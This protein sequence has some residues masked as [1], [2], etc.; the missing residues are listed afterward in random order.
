MALRPG[1]VQWL[2]DEPKLIY[3]ARNYNTLPSDDYF[4]HLRFMPAVAG[5]NGTR[6][7][8][9][10][11]APVWFYQILWLATH[12]L[13]AIAMLHALF[14]GV[15]TALALFWLARVMR[16]SPWLAVL[17]MLSPWIWYYS[18]QLWDNNFN[19]PLSAL[20]LAAYG[21]FI[22]TRRTWSLRLAVFCMVIMPLVHFMS[23]PLIIP[24][25]IHLTAFHFRDVW[26]SKWNLLTIASGIEFLAWPYWR[27][28]YYAHH[29]SIPGGLSAVR[30]WFFPLLGPHHLTGGGM[31]MLLGDDWVSGLNVFVGSIV[32]ISQAYS[33][34]AYLIC[35]VG[36]ALAAVCAWRI[37]IRAGSASTL[38]HLAAISLATW[39]CQTVL[40][41]FDR[42]YDGPH[43]FNATWVI[44]LVFFWIAIDVIC[45]R[46][47]DW[48][49]VLRVGLVLH[50]AALITVLAGGYYCIIHNTGSRRE[51]GYGTT[52]SNQIAAMRE[53]N[54]FSAGSP[55]FIE[56]NQWNSYKWAFDFLQELIPAPPGPRPMAQLRIHYR[57]DD[58]DD[59]RIIVDHF[60]LSTAPSHAP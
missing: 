16:V 57:E 7:V 2:N 1:D 50:G 55:R 53:I 45:R 40:Y 34:L 6:G 29:T 5:L 26:K 18:R 39:L 9:Y 38:D 42:A 28:L 12:D 3:Y 36:M 41:G 35:W 25:A 44:F 10:G 27:T 58:P 15:V 37:F 11:P 51:K 14:A 19:I 33:L 54:R 52:L 8:L 17:A 48:R 32:Y 49:S 21:D 43:Y 22:T 20:L 23:L 24:V 30:G 46:R 31:N 56:I 4:I 59:A 60:P 47:S 13:I